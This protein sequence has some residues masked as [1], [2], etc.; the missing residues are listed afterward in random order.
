M[1][2][3]AARR[4]PEPSARRIVGLALPALGVLAAEPLYLLF[5]IAVVGRLGALAL[6]GLAVGG[7]ILAQVSTQLTFLSY[8]TTAR[9]SRR[10]GSGD[11]RGAV[12][13]GVQATYLAVGIGLAIVIAVQLLARPV[14]D[15]IAGGGDIATEALQW[16]RI[17]VFGAPLILVAMAGNG[18]LRGVQNTL[19]PLRFVLAGLAV[20]AVLCP[21]LVH[22]LLGAP[23]WELAG[24]AVAN[25]VGQSVTA[26]CFV[27][28]LLR[29]GVSL[30]PRPDVMRAQ[31]V[32]GRDLIL[33]SLAFQACFLS[34]AAVAARF[35]AAAVAAHQVV[36]QLWNLVALTLDSLAIAAQTLVGA[37]L[38]AGHAAQA[39]G[40]ARRLTGWS[41]VFALALA[42][43]FALGHTVIPPLFTGDAAVLGQIDV[44]W[45]F[46][47]AIM[48]VAGVVF[49][50]DGV[51]LGAGDAAFLR[52]ATL[53]CAVVGFLPPIWLSLEF[54]WGLAGIWSG[55]TVFMVLRMLA[56]VWR[57]SSGRWTVVGADIQAGR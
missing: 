4:N 28:A 26:T 17:A 29:S 7:L 45:W 10:H 43:A 56:V 20:S 30:R 49:A 8:G 52:N 23:R 51:L 41:T 31:V 21:I 27:A 48:P 1:A 6:A 22:G 15:V 3:P 36:L 33:R 13:E 40:L 37:A 11:E 5:D 14:V 35:G 16:L 2:D 32:L 9:A 19:R 25:V 54:D 50:L 39:R 34:A 46:F 18:W 44:V 24:S 57:T 53:G 47:V 12:E 38:G 42:A 55:L